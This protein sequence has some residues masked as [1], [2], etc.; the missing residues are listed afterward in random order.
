MGTR[1]GFLQS[2]KNWGKKAASKAGKFVEN[3]AKGVRKLKP[4]I[5]RVTDF[6][7]GVGDQIDKYLNL[8]LDAADK[9]GEGLTDIGNG[10][11]VI[12]TVGKKALEFMN[13]PSFPSNQNRIADQQSQKPKESFLNNVLNK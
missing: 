5:D 13:A 12:E 8:G 10:A 6:I 11:N 1:P 2:I 4:V 3:V 9:I 7:P